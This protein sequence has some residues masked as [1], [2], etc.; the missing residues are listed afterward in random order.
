MLISNGLFYFLLLGAFVKSLHCYEWVFTIN[1]TSFFQ[2][3]SCWVDL[4]DWGRLICLDVLVSVS[5]LQLHVWW[6]RVRPWFEGSL[7]LFFPFFFF[8]S[9][10]F[11]ETPLFIDVVHS[12][13]L[14]CNKNLGR[15]DFR[16]FIF[17]NVNLPLRLD[18][19]CCL[20]EQLFF[21]FYDKD[22]GFISERTSTIGNYFCLMDS[23]VL[24]SL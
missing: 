11:V 24:L 18:F 4:T 7:K 17:S 8:F 12:S 10:L 23:L 6:I 15:G 21:I 19:F 1:L 5:L 22:C 3:R 16:L 13:L 9:V 20:G 14:T 2:G